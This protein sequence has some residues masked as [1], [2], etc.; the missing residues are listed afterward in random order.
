MERPVDDQHSDASLLRPAVEPTVPRAA[1]AL[2]TGQG[3]RPPGLDL[4]PQEPER[5]LATVHGAATGLTAG[6]VV[7]VTGATP[8]AIGLL[9]F[10]GAV[11]WQSATGRW[12]LLL[13]EMIVAL[14]AVVFGTQVARFGQARARYT[15]AAARSRYRG[16]YLTGEDLDAPARMLLRRAQDAVDTVMDA[17]VT[18]AGLLDEATA[19]AAQEWDI[20][21]SLRD[22]ARLRARRAE[23]TRSTGL[24]TPDGGPTP[25][26][27]A[28]AL[29]RQHLDAA[30]AAERSVTE[31][32]VTLE[33]YA[34]E[35]R[36][37]DA[38]YGNWR[39]HARLAELTGPH[40]NLLARTAADSHGIAELAEMTERARVIRSTFNERTTDGGIP[41]DGDLVPCSGRASLPARCVGGSEP[42]PRCVQQQAKRAHCRHSHGR[43]AHHVGEVMPA[44]A[45]DAKRG[46]DQQ[47]EQCRQAGQR[48]WPRPPPRRPRREQEQH[49]V[50]GG[51]RHHAGRMAAGIGQ[52]AKVGAVEQR[53]QHPLVDPGSDEYRR[54][55]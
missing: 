48:P 41:D 12:A 13:M 14:T 22:Q 11:S 5:R 3:A 53:L 15:A 38:A 51:D 20:A 23:I 29:L 21:V 31:R 8:W 37:A 49:D 43:A 4:L 10:Q 40:L 24:T 34:A 45:D 25:N 19:L 1:R 46:D 47:G 36:Q 32:V 55:G 28:T 30:L 18:E 35:V 6:M 27:P 9:I 52:R 50:A 54:Q 16:R 39:A 17:V 2:L 33:R 26:T 44:Q 7:A 42:A